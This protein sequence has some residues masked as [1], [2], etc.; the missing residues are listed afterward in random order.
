MLKPLRWLLW[1]IARLFLS[2]RYRVRVHGLEQV[3][4]LRGPTLILPNHPG[5]IEPP[6]VITTLWPLLHPRPLIYG[7]NVHNVVLYPL[8]RLV[9]ALEVPDM[10]Q[11]GA[12]AREQAQQ[13]VTAVIEGLHRGVNH[14]M[15]PSGRLQRNGV[16]VLGGAR[17]LTDILKAVPDA[18]IILVRTRGVWGSMFSCAPTGL[19]PDILRVL[20]RG[21]LLLLG[22]LLVLA[23]RRQVDITFERLDRSRL[24][25]LERSKINSWF[26]AWYNAGGPEKPTFVPYHFSLGPRSME[27]PRMTEPVEADLS[28]VKPETRQAVAQI[29]GDRLHRELA[30]DELEPETPLDQLGLDSLDRME[31]SLAVEQ[32]FGFS[33]AEVPATVGQLWALAQ[34]LVEKAPPRPPDPAWFHPPPS[35][36][37]PQIVGDTMAE[38]FVNRALA[39][40]G[41][42]AAADDRTGV[43]TYERLL[44]GAL[45]LARRLARLPA[46]NVG[47]MLPA[48]AGCFVAFFALHLAGKLPV[49]LNWTTGPANLDNAVRLTELTHVITSRL[50]LDRVGVTI[51]DVQYVFLDELAKKVGRLEKLRAWLTVRLRP[52]AIQKRVP[53]ASAGDPAV[54]LFTSGSEKAPKAVP[55]THRN[56]LTN[57]RAGMASLEVTRKDTALAFLPPFHSFG[58]SV[59][60]VLPLLSGLRVIYHPDPTD[61]ASLVRKIEAYRPTILVGTP[62]FVGHILN[63]ARRGQLESLRL[64]VV[65]AEKCPDAVFDGCARLAPRAEVLEGYGITECSPIVTV[66]RPRAARRG[67]VGKALPGV[68]LCVVDVDTVASVP[69]GKMGMLLVA[70]P[71]LFPGYLGTENPPPFQERDGK[72]WYLTGDL[73]VIDADGLVRL[74][75]RLKRFL[76]AGGEMISLPAL[77]EPFARLFPPTQEGPRV[78]VE[79]LETEDG[80][81]IVLFTTEEFSL[82][83][84]NARLQEEGFRGVMRLDEVRR[85]EK[86]PILGTGKTDYK[87]LRVWLTAGEASPSRAPGSLGLPNI[88]PTRFRAKERV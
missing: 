31:V 83:E 47:L 44:L 15:W 28:R 59:T 51:K 42:V 14:I 84:A 77:E 71:L 49:L 27:F 61:A 24:P 22:N 33:G 82:R 30:A 53:R 37:P 60:G 62:T 87:V 79:G 57:E 72:R 81:R 12:S 52:G 34:G 63:R 3:R 55:L 20:G 58:L 6:L 76:K 78:A 1:V 9:D 73:A 8:M 80:R 32:R 54:V 74:A 40:L 11:A 2:L 67:T 5:L 29:L 46:A 70:G 56:L 69:P 68:E 7:G 17:A 45:L 50:F 10:K 21:V 4:G 88:E 48:S 64:V 23:P 39:S 36:K 13:A 85:V 19:P 66:N 26:G 65:G 41:D 35:E 75:G 38:A 16:E 18:E 86:I 25:P 43:L